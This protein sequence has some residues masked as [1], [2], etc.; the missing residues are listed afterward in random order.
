MYGIMRSKVLSYN[1]YIFPPNQLI[2]EGQLFH[3]A[4]EQVSTDSMYSEVPLAKDTPSTLHIKIY[5]HATYGYRAFG[6]P[7]IGG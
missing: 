4:K 2:V 5:N 7:A 3:S 1:F 6:K